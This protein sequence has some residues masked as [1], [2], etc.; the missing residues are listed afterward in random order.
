MRVVIV[1]A[2]PTGLFT[3]M[4]LARRGHAVTV[5]D[6]DP[7]PDADGSWSR[8]GVMQFHHPHAFRAQVVEALQAELP[9]VWHDLLAA[10]A[11]PV[12]VPT[13]PGGPEA[14]MAVRC[15]RLT[16]ERVLRSAAARQP[17]LVLRTGQVDD[18][19]VER[20]RATGVRVDGVRSDA[21][22]VIAASGR[23]GRLG[24]ELRAPAQGGD[25]GIA[26]VSR[27]YRLRPGAEPGPMNLPL[28]QVDVHPGY[29]AIVFLHDNGIFSTLIARGGDDRALAGL[30]LPEAFEA[31]TRA[32]PTLAAWTDPARAHPYTAVLPG[33]RLHNT[34]QGQLDDTGAVAVPGLVFVGDAVCT[35]NPAVGRGVTTSLLQAR[36]LVR[37]LDD[38]GDDLVGLTL[39]FDR[40]CRENIAPWFDDHVHWDAELA[41][42]WAGADVDLTRP[43]PSDLIVAATEADRSLFAVVGPY[44]GMRAL[45][46][47][48]DAVRPRVRE[49]YAGGWRPP[50]PGGPTRDELAQ[51][52][53]TETAAGRPRSEAH[54]AAHS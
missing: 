30:R 19:C 23:A 46:S 52:V 8:R 24:R 3:G 53:A 2:G 29:Q 40:W 54:A 31:A 32:I 42:R 10:G 16:F 15:R 44:L 6:R 21:D 37:L 39:A 41:R 34:Y 35:T 17:G 49:I 14:L 13:G 26:Y 1:G 33:G 27:Q 18:V 47:S 5:V 45:P 4:V 12:M 25:C 43:L 38:Q 20:G 36:E 50:V 22:L 51:L 28:G 7:G 11:E 48:L 9:E